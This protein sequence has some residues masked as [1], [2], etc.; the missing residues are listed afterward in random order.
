MSY[1]KSE[2]DSI[3]RKYGHDI[4]LQRR[5]QNETGEPEFSNTFEIHTVRHMES[6]SLPDAQ[7]EMAEGIL[8]T[9]ER[10]YWFRTNAKPFEGDR[11]YELDPRINQT[12]WTIDVVLP[13]RGLNGDLEFWKAGATRTR[14]N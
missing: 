4:Y 1:M 8:N 5:I 13:M 2:F 9:S 11:I 6:G 12:V 14:P 7:Q 3:L 10:V